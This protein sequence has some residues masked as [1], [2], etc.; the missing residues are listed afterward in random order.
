MKTFFLLALLY[1]VNLALLPHECELS[2]CQPPCE[3][4]MEPDYQLDIGHPWEKA[5]CTCPL[6]TCPSCCTSYCEFGNWICMAQCETGTCNN[7]AGNI[8]YLNIDH[9]KTLF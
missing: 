3:L 8:V 6:S 4:K 7:T 2:M 9:Y 5:V 1:T